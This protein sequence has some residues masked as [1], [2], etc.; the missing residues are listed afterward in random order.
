MIAGKMDN[1]RKYLEGA[2]ET[3]E[4]HRGHGS[5][6]GT[7]VSQ[8]QYLPK[9]TKFFVLLGLRL[10][11]ESSSLAEPLR[12]RTNED[13]PKCG[14]TSLAVAS[15]PSTLPPS[16]PLISYSG[17]DEPHSCDLALLGFLS[18]SRL[19]QHQSYSCNRSLSWNSFC[20]WE[21]E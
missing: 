9:T 19:H 3:Q 11:V 4:N 5:E 13:S 12:K 1:T 18:L 16:L 14:S 15:T 8:Q 6:S 20:V 21:G 17:N 2:A 7:G 10:S